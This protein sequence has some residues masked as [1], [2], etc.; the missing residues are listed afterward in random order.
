MA[1]IARA[2]FRV[3]RAALHKPYVLSF[4][5]LDGFETVLSR[6]EWDDGRQSVGEVV[7]LPGYGAET[8]EDVVHDAGR[9]RE[10][11]GG[12]TADAARGRLAAAVPAAP[13]ACSLWLTALDAR[14]LDDRAATTAAGW[15]VPIVYPTSSEAHDLEGDVEAALAD[16]YR[17]VKVK[18]GKDVAQDVAA[19]GALGRGRWEADVR[20]RFDANQGYTTD[21]ARRFLGA[22]AESLSGPT[23]LLEQPLPMTDWDGAAA[24]A[25]EFG[26]PLML[27]ESIF[28]ERDVDRAADIGCAWVKFKLCKQGGTADVLRLARRAKAKGLRVTCGN[29]V[30][31]DVVNFLELDMTARHRSLFDGA[32]ESNGFVKLRDSIQHADLRVEGGHAV[33]TGETMNRAA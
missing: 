30:A 16:G 13:F 4:R 3:Q 24:L 14:E 8:L 20:F 19:V 33:S 1:R 23:E 17:T 12:L 10:A 5:T 26:V 28:D 29:G 21:A 18:V 6:L 22:V 25:G 9:W 32:S 7:P 31:T 11:L 15:R 27:D 2:S